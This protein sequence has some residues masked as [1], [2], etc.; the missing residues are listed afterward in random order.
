MLLSDRKVQVSSGPFDGCVA[1][2]VSGGG[3]VAGAIDIGSSF[4]RKTLRNIRKTNVQPT[5]CGLP[6][7]VIDAGNARNATREAEN[8]ILGNPSN[9]CC[10]I[11]NDF[12]VKF[13][14]ATE[15]PVKLKKVYESTIFLYSN[16][17]SVEFM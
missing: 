8:Y 5:N 2:E 14:K 12:E 10:T 3:V 7:K 16:E 9:N 1:V 4:P 6:T 11:E 15:L 17:L 13:W